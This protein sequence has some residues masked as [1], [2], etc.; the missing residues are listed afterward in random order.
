MILRKPSKEE[1]TAIARI[2]HKNMKNLFIAIREKPVSVTKLKN[3][4]L[5]N[6][7]RQKMLVLENNNKIKGF[8]WYYTKKREFYL[9]EIVV[10]EKGADYGTVLMNHLINEAK[11]TKIKRINLD[12]HYKNICAQ[13]FF[14]KFKFTNRTIEMNLDI[15]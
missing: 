6:Y 5:K 7:S 3:K 15:K 8:I 1:L 4:L 12:V 14:K 2:I 9:D 11:R 13:E 10:I